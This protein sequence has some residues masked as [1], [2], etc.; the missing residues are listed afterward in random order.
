MNPNFPNFYELLDIPVDANLSE[1][2]SGHIQAAARDSSLAH[3]KLCDAALKT[4]ENSEARNRYD[5]ELRDWHK[6]HVEMGTNKTD[7]ATRTI[8]DV[9]DAIE[10]AE[11]CL[12]ETGELIFKNRFSSQAKL[13]SARGSVH[14]LC[15]SAVHDAGRVSKW[16]DEV[17]EFCDQA[18]RHVAE[19]QYLMRPQAKN[20]E[21]QIRKADQEARKAAKHVQFLTQKAKDYEAE[22]DKLVGAAAPQENIIKRLARLVSDTL[23]WTKNALELTIK[24]IKYSVLL[25]VILLVG[26][27]ILFLVGAMLFR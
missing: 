11:K 3:Q 18:G 6:K 15:Q 7:T 13:K 16:A 12:E 19:F 20:L 25:T 21:V 24:I 10:A 1:I 26:G 23:G 4:L 8:H 5:M 14:R 27:L 22:I 2:R 17:I 9:N